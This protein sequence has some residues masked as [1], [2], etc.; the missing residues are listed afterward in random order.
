MRKLISTFL[1]CTCMSVFSQEKL[2]S[3]SIGNVKIQYPQS[4]YSFA[5]AAMVR[6]T[7]PVV[8]D[9]SFRITEPF[10]GNEEDYGTLCSSDLNNC[11][12]LEEN[13]PFYF[14]TENGDLHMLSPTENIYSVTHGNWSGHEV[15]P[16][17][18]ISQ[19]GISFNYGGQCY[20]VVL[21]DNK[22]TVFIRFF[23]G[24]NKGCKNM[25]KCFSSQMK[26]I[27]QFVKLLSS[28]NVK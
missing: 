25:R 3:Y 19:R 15:F 1:L 14:K 24:K 16:L 9:F 11:A 22:N 13:S 27:D 2:Q 21:S 23:L 12:Q 18:G 7:D 26:S 8:Y 10:L 4:M 5:K 28:N 20:A 17:C 6:Q